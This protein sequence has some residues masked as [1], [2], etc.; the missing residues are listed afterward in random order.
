M[1]E[2][3]IKDSVWYEAREVL[4]LLP[5]IS[6]RTLRRAGI[7]SARLSARRALYLGRD[8]NAWLARLREKGRKAG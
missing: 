1:T 8:V 5:G 4:A 2:R 6:M 3:E 7:P